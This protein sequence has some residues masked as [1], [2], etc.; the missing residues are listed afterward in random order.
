MQDIGIF[1]GSSTGNSKAVAKQIQKEFGT[2]V[3]IVYDVSSAKITDI[4]KH[5]I[6]LFYFRNWRIRI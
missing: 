2:D 6:W 1:Y 4:E 5:Y 3:A